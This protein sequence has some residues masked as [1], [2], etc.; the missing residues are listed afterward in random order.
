LRARCALA[1]VRSRRVIPPNSPDLQGR[2]RRGMIVA[3]K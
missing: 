2:Q 3:R 1:R